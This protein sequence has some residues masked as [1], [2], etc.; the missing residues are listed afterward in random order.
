MQILSICSLQTDWNE[1]ETT[2]ILELIN[3]EYESVFEHPVSIKSQ[4][5]SSHSVTRRITEEMTLVKLFKLKV[6]NEINLR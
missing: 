5:I 3:R 6:V 1:E 4:K 2:S